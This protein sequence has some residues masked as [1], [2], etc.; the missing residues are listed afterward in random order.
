MMRKFLRD[1]EL[2]RTIFPEGMEGF[3][4][5]LDC[6]EKQKGTLLEANVRASSS[7]ASLN[8]KLAVQL[9]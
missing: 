4:Q 6:E 1:K 3:Q 8:P 5:L 9:M 7:A 2:K